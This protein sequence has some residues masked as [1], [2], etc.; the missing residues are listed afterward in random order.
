MSKDYLNAFDDARA[1]TVKPAR[2]DQWKGRFDSVDLQ[3]RSRK[4]YDQ[5]KAQPVRPAKEPKQIG[6]R[7]REGDYAALAD[8]II[9]GER[10]NQRSPE[11]YDRELFE[12]LF[13]RYGR[14]W[15][16]ARMTELLRKFP[17]YKKGGP[18]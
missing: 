8:Y 6:S 14:E 16:L 11:D 3:S 1:V 2:P 5:Q 18:L 7:Y 15:V 9:T 12:G 4:H 17:S 13:L 10:P